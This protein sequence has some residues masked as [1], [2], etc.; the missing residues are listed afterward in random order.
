L[1]KSDRRTLL[2][3]LLPA[4]LALCAALADAP[5]IAG[6]D[7]GGGID[8]KT[9]TWLKLVSD[10][11]GRAT[12][13]VERGDVWGFKPQADD[14]TTDAFAK[15]L[16]GYWGL[17]ARQAIVAADGT[18]SLKTKGWTFYTHPQTGEIV[19]EILNPYAGQTVHC[20]PL[21]GPAFT[22]VYGAPGA[23]P[24]PALDLRQRRLDEH[25][26]VEVD[27]ISRFKPKDTAWFKLEADLIS[28]ACRAD[29]LDDPA[30]RFIPSIWSHNVVAEWQTWMQMHG[31][32]G[33]ILFKG[34]GAFIP[35]L[36]ATPAPLKAAIEQHFPSSFDAIKAWS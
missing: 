10:L 15:R 36:D 28:Y 18:I 5:A 27:R 2:A 31:T 13:A 33:H 23:P 25:A 8:G 7:G 34:D 1:T 22:A 6:E 4:S 32:P 17:L 24:G 14:L 26:W 20:P 12:F 21:S 3:G 11:S 16:Y 30:K 9:R 35:N 29:D 19:T